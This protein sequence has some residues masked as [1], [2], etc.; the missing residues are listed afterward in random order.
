M[1]AFCYLSHIHLAKRAE[2]SAARPREGRGC[3]GVGRRKTKKKEKKE[4]TENRRESACMPHKTEI[5]IEQPFPRSAWRKEKTEKTTEK[6]K[7]D[8]ARGQTTGGGVGANAAAI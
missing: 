1:Q 4:T 5:A 2:W 3:D 6:K 8:T 7:N